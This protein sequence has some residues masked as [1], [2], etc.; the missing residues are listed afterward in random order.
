MSYTLGQAA[1][2]AG[3]SKMTLSRA[4]KKGTISAAKKDSGGYTIEPSEL[5][6]V[7]PAVTVLHDNKVSHVTERYTHDTDMLHSLKELESKLQV[8][9]ERLNGKDALLNEKEKQ[10]VEIRQDRDDWK[11]QAQRLLLTNQRPVDG[12]QASA[13]TPQ[14]QATQNASTVKFLALALIL[15][16]AA[17]GVVFILAQN[18][19]NLPLPSIQSTP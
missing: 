14:A 8:T 4:I 17:V 19:Q 1:K 10:L 7:F 16:L 6:R 3:I 18:G 9:L 12:L 2:A 13:A 11:E 15:V 5:H